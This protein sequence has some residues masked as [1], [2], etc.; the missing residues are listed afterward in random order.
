MHVLCVSLTAR[1]FYSP[2]WIILQPLIDIDF[3]IIDL[4]PQVSQHTL[5]TSFLLAFHVLVEAARVRDDLLQMNFCLL[6]CGSALLRAKHILLRSSLKLLQV[7][8]SL[9]QVHI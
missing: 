9:L 6:V 7:A 3:S 4:C 1:A 2:F 5:D 8:A